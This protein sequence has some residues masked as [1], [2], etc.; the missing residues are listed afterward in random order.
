MI[1]EDTLVTKQYDLDNTQNDYM[2]GSNVV[3]DN[4]RMSS[5]EDLGGAGWAL[6]SLSA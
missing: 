1:F 4:A 3:L 2:K 6:P 5:G